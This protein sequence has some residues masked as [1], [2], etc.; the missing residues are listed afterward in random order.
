MSNLQERS[1]KAV[2]LIVGLGCGFFLLWIITSTFFV[3][4]LIV[5]DWVRI[6]NA[7]LLGLCVLLMKT[8]I[9]RKFVIAGMIIGIFA[10]LLLFLIIYGAC[11]SLFKW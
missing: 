4:T 11:I 2:D 1:T 5:Q 7:V 10:P 9:K 8:R 3:R 6:L